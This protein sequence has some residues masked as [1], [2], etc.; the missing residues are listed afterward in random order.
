[1]IRKLCYLFI[2]ILCMLQISGCTGNSTSSSSEGYTITDS[3]GKTLHM[4]SKPT[5]IIST[6]VFADEIL[7]DLVA[8]DRIVAMDT[9]I[10]DPGLSMAVESAKDVPQE[11]DNSAEH[12]ISLHPDLVIV[13]ESQVKLIQSLEG[14]G[15]PVFV[16]KDAKLIKDIP[17]EIRMLGQAVGEPE[18]AEH[19]IADMEHQLAAI[20]TKVAALTPSQKKRV[21]LVLRFGPIGGEGT[22]FHEVLTRAGT[23]DTYNEVRPPQIT[24]KGTTLILSKEEFVQSNPDMIIMGNWSQGGAYKDSYQQLEEMYEDPAYSSMKA[25]QEK[26]IIVIPQRY[27]NCLSHH[28]T[29]G[30]EAVY[31]AVYE[32]KG[33]AS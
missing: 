32:G 28:V 13:G 3:R 1:M 15:L 26:Q 19:L 31:Q 5:R 20:D 12:M 7:L 17:E 4:K 16:Y 25:I 14:A 23:I 2:A 24:E 10:H 6:Y 30:I 29:Q 8:H 11:V 33:D 21:M 22:I 27:V 9:W 18:K